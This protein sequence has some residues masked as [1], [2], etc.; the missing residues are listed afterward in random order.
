VIRSE[1]YTTINE[2]R[3]AI[4]V[5]EW[6]ESID[7]VIVSRR[8]MYEGVVLFSSQ[9][10]FVDKMSH[11]DIRLVLNEPVST[12]RSISLLR[13][14]IMYS[15]MDEIMNVRHDVVDTIM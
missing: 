6:R 1:Y 5:L 13:G 12:V 2:L 9:V 3:I 15:F 11:Q 8:Y 10:E 14:S 4:R 7:V